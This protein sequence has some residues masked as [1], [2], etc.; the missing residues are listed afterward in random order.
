MTIN[1]ATFIY[2]IVSQNK[3]TNLIDASANIANN[4]VTKTINIKF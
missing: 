3:K 4:L 2:S 1:S